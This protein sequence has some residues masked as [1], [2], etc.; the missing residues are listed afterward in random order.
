MND[1]QLSAHTYNGLENQY[2]RMIRFY[3]RAIN[4]TDSIDELDFLTAFFQNCFHLK[5]WLIIYD[6]DA[7]IKTKVNN[8]IN[9]NDEL[10]MCRDICNGMK[11]LRLTN[12]SIDNNFAF[13]KEYDPFT[14]KMDSKDYH[15][16]VYFKEKKFKLLEIS[17]KCINIWNNFLFSSLQLKIE[18]YYP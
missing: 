2:Q 9:S 11:H 1:V 6:V 13:F 18:Y 15:W 8:L 5:D 4:S 7:E 12:P 3:K 17:N 10:K 16:V 14:K